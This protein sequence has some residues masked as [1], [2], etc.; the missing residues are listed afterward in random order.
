MT[1]GTVFLATIIVSAPEFGIALV[2]TSEGSSDIKNLLVAHMPMNDSGIGVVTQSNYVDGTAV[3]CLL[4][5]NKPHKAY[6][7]AP[8]NYA[9]GDKNDSLYGRAVYNTASYNESDSKAFVNAV[10]QL[11]S[12][13]LSIDFQNFAH[14]VDLNALPGDN[15]Q[16]DMNG[17]AGIHIGRFIAQLRGSPIAFIDVAN[18]THKI[19][20]VAN[21][22]EQHLPL[23]YILNGRYLSVHN[24]ATSEDEAFGIQDETSVVLNDG[25]LEFAD[26]NAIPLYR[27]QSTEGAAVDGKEELVVA[28]PEGGRH[29]KNTEPPILAKRRTALDGALTEASAQSIDS[30]KSPAIKAIHQVAYSKDA[31]PSDQ[32]DILQPYE[33]IPQPIEKQEAPSADIEVS[34]AA[35]NK[36]IDTLFTGDYLEKLQAKMAELGLRISTKDGLLSNQIKGQLVTGPT[37]AQQYALPPMIQ[38]TDPVTGKVSTYYNST[39]F[40]TQEPDGSIL[41]CDGYGSEIRMSRGNIYISPA[42]DLFLRPG[43]D[44]SA[45]SPRHQSFNAQR[46]TTINSADAVYIRAVGD[47]KM[48]GATGGSGMVTLECDATTSTTLSGLM[49][50]STAGTTLTGKDVYIGINSGIGSTEGIEEPQNAGTIIIDACSNGK[51]NMRSNEQVL[52]SNR[53][54]MLANMTTTEEGSAIIIDATSI[55]LFTRYVNIPAVVSMVGMKSANKITVV[56]NGSQQEVSLVFA[57]IPQLRVEGSV[58]VGGSFDCSKSGRF[59][60][61]LAAK[62]V[63]STSPFCGV[64]SYKFTDPFA[65][66]DI[67]KQQPISVGQDVAS[68]ILQLS[69]TIYKDSYISTNSFAFPVSYNIDPAIRVPGMLWQIQT[70]DSG[71]KWKEPEMRSPDGTITMCYPGAD[72]WST[73]TIS[74]AKYQVASLNEGYIVNTL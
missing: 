19:R 54:C 21:Q 33:A 4:D 47:L 69:Q 52:D 1:S 73:A 11:L 57:N 41:I 29:Y 26:D 16:I 31:N 20:M 39:S 72:V 6:I 62:G 8:A 23:S 36:L 43:R 74:K 48:A 68:H 65:P 32:Q 24:V 64:A 40:I 22:I 3:V 38:L 50:R 67:E 15:D 25:V 56:R 27:L 45:M 59:C 70:G 28:F 53:I 7:L 35:I 10:E 46:T 44:L 30:I 58:L 63:V 51:I 18:I 66:I 61:Q 12:T 34:D 17:N 5:A 9:I 2:S 42:L 13:S 71:P 49:I 60:G 55:G 14:G 37:D